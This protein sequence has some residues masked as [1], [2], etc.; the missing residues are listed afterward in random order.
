MIFISVDLPAPFSPRTAWI[1]PGA[2]FRLTRSLALTA[3]YCLLMPVSSRRMGR[4]SAGCSGTIG[5]TPVAAGA[6]DVGLD[7]VALVAERHPGER[8]LMQ[9]AGHLVPARGDRAERRL[10]DADIG[11]RA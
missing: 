5:T 2:T 8:P 7:Q 3:G 10:P 4:D 11:G 1:W 9:C 6:G